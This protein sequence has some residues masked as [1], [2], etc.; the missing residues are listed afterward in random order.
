MIT[1]LYEAEYGEGYFKIIIESYKDEEGFKQNSGVFITKNTKITIG[2][3][4]EHHDEWSDMPDIITIPD[5]EIEK[6]VK[7]LT[8]YLK[9][10]N[11]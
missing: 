9:L 5:S 1:K 7:V 11:F 8:D 2:K 10:R 6:V 4:F 3:G